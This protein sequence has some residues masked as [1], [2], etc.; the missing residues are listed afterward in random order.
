M[1]R[2]DHHA[3]DWVKALRAAEDGQPTGEHHHHACADYTGTWRP[4]HVATW[5]RHDVAET[6]A[7]EPSRLYHETATHGVYRV[8]V[9]PRSCDIDTATGACRRWV[10]NE[11]TRW[12]GGIRISRD[13]ISRDYFRPERAAVRDSL[14]DAAKAYRATGET[15]D[16]D[17]PDR[18][19]RNSRW[20]GGWWD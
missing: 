16:V 15:D 14:R 12:Y 5:I 13:V 1:S 19:T 8:P 6:H 18:Q 3:P 4:T 20:H 9:E 2:T 11:R 7:W 17:P 10:A